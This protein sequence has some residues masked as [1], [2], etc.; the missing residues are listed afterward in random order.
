MEPRQIIFKKGGIGSL[1]VVKVHNYLKSF[2]VVFIFFKKNVILNCFLT[3]LYSI[4][5]LFYLC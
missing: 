4:L 3:Q 2:K 1:P 5:T